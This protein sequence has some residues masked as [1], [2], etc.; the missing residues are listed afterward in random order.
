MECRTLARDHKVLTK[1]NKIL[2]MG[3]PN[4]GKSVIFSQ[5]TGINVVS[6]NYCGTTVAY[7]E[8]NLNIG[9]KDYTLIDVPGTYSLQPTSE[10]EAVATRFMES[11]ALAVICVL[12][13]SNLE[14]KSLIVLRE[15]RK[16]CA[17]CRWLNPC[18]FRRRISVYLVI[19][20]HLRN[21]TR[22]LKTTRRFGVYQM[23][24][25]LKLR[26]AQ[27]ERNRW[28]NS[29]G[30]V[31]QSDRNLHLQRVNFNMAIFYPSAIRNLLVLNN[32]LFI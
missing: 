26:V 12:D 9:G 4:V 13:A 31:V 10:A 32:L 30:S 24:I 15:I 8:G 29:S 14:R 1:P 5:M 23:I 16:L 6:S 21:K 17:I 19:F 11:G 20:D 7:M 18:S 22:A 3:N 25:F 27:L 28:L 2:L